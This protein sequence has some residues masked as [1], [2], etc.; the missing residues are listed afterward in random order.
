MR[1]LYRFAIRLVPVA[2]L[3]TAASGALAQQP[4]ASSLA[5]SAPG[6]TLTDLS[7]VGTGCPPGSVSLSAPPSLSVWLSLGSA[8]AK[9]GPGVP[10]T[11]EVKN[12]LLSFTLHVPPGYTV[13]QTGATVEGVATLPAGV[14][15]QQTTGYFLAGGPTFSSKVTMTA[16]Q[17][18]DSRGVTTPVNFAA[19][20]AYTHA[21]AI[22]PANLQWS[23]CGQDVIANVNT[24][25]F[26]SNGAN[27]GASGSAAIDLVILPSLG[28][29]WTTC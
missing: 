15:A 25:V 12:C 6:I 10:V 21:D 22:P 20:A 8:N 29:T 2:V 14:L 18:T 3:A 23:P 16:S 26:V 11:E 5:P 7:F 19:G 27:P 13:A 1:L 28:I 4:P 17:F 24:T 9:D